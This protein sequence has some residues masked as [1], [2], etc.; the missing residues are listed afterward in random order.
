MLKAPNLLPFFC[1]LIKAILFIYI[2]VS[3]LAIQNRETSWF[4][5]YNN[6][7]EEPLKTPRETLVQQGLQCQR[8]KMVEN[9]KPK[10]F[11]QQASHFLNPKP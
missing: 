5:S 3:W 11:L 2:R 10:P 4:G 8:K 9:L 1:G 7:R 6:R